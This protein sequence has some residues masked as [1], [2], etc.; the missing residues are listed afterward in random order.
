MKRK[1]PISK[2][3]VKPKGPRR[4]PARERDPDRLWLD[5]G[6]CYLQIVDGQY[7][8]TDADELLSIYR[9]PEV[10]LQTTIVRYGDT[11]D[12]GVLVRAAAIPWFEI[13]KQLAHD[14]TFM[15]QF[16]DNPRKFEEFIA[17]AYREAEF[18]EVT[19][20]P[21]SR[22]RGRDVIATR[23]RVCSVRVLDQAKAYSPHH[24]VNHN[25]VR[26][27]LGVLSTDENTSKGII[28]TTSDFE[29]LIWSG[30]EFDKFMPYRL[31]LKNGENLLKWLRDIQLAKSV[32]GSENS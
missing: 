24:L 25:D 5:Y 7:V 4:G 26:A 9:G 20:T 31:E 10:L 11:T 30:G 8:V 3:F 13:F 29:P 23:S 16:A 18:D 12:D 14:P 6:E 2:P 27:M 17:G 32:R 22:D 1:L 19:L 15:F 28:T 21:R